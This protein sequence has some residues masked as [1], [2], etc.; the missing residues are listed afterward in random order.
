LNKIRQW[1]V[2]NLV[3][4]LIFFFGFALRIYFA[5]KGASFLVQKSVSD[6]AFYYFSIA[7]HL[8]QG[9][10]F[11]FD[12]LSQ[13]SG[14]HPL[15]AVL[16]APFY[17]LFPNNSMLS[18]HLVL[19][20]G[21]LIDLATAILLYMTIRHL[22]SKTAA[23]W[24]T[25]FYFFN[26]SVI[27]F[28]IDG[29]ETSINVF[30]IMLVSFYYLK[31]VR[32][33]PSLTTG[34]LVLLGLLGGLMI[35]A[36]SDSVFFLAAILLDLILTGKVKER[37]RPAAIILGIAFLVILPWLVWVSLA[38][39]SPIQS[40]GMAYPWLLHQQYLA[41]AGTYFSPALVNRVFN[42]LSDYTWFQLVELTGLRR[43]ISE[44]TFLI[45][46]LLLV[47][48]LL[49]IN[50]KSNK[51]KALVENFKLVNFLLLGTVVLLSFHTFIRWYPR[52]W[53]FAPVAIILALYFAFLLNWADRRWGASARRG[54]LAGLLGLAIGYG[55]LDQG[56]NYWMR[57][58]Y[59]HQP[60]M[61]Q[62]ALWLK[63]H[64]PPSSRI[65][66]FNVGIYAYF[67][68]RTVL[69]LDGVIDKDAFAALNEK[70]LTGYLDRRG[71][72]YVI[73]YAYSIDTDYGPYLGEEWETK[74]TKI[75]ELSGT[76]NNTPIVVYERVK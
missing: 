69:N 71:V 16:I 72:D 61:Y 37:L 75:A 15:W 35:L 52:Y 60:E 47:G 17:L 67:S 58:F 24:G 62:A 11:T 64:T 14:F 56:I 49:T 6:D 20:L 76:W 28:S 68:D 55:Y 53:Y 63:V 12:G 31:Y 23:L 19:S 21:A 5:A 29:L 4:L 73:D 8:V 1:A 48:T 32:A 13:T 40:S 54:L 33:A 41:E 51:N 42:V 27:S 46:V 43:Y 2:E 38:V 22:T 34:S 7:R 25:A 30:M 70:N 3:I 65:A 10:G 26:P 36:R 66:G 39:G 50:L 74:F 59:P 44:G 57:G 18:L 9:Q 45:G